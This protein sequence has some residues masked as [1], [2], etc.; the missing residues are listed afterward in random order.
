M[1]GPRSGKLPPDDLDR[2]LRSRRGAERPEVRIGPAVGEDAAVIRVGAAPYLVVAS[3]PIVGAERGAGR[4]LVRV[5]AND[6]AC[7][8]ADPAYL[9]ATLIFPA[10]SEESAADRVMEEIDRECRALGCAVVGGHTEFSP[11]YDRPI[12]SATLLGWSD[13]LLSAD[14]IRPGDVLLATKRVGLEGMSILASDRPDLLAPFLSEGEIREVLSWAE[15]TSVLEEARLLRDLARFLHDP[16]EGGFEGA[17]YEVERLCGR[18]IG[19]DRASVP[20]DPLTRRA[21]SALGF[22]PL[23]LIASGTLLAVLPPETLPEALGR[24]AGAGVE[25]SLVGRVEEGPAR[26]AADCPEELW[27]LLAM[28]RGGGA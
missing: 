18:R 15:R 14:R 5:N 6:V 4:L 21:A 11:Y 12:L 23:R 7:K 10:S 2:L 19:L 20:V 8:G 24:L 16:T 1:R 13:R 25:A 3:D 9:M 22:D 26:S 28:P 27:R 17:L